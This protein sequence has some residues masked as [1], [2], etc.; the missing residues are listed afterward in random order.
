[1][2]LA[3]I[4]SLALIGFLTG[5]SKTSIGGI[6]LVNAALLATILPAK[7]SMGVM[8]ILLIAGDLFAIGIYKKHVEWKMLRSLIWPIIFGIFIGVYFLS[9]ATNDSL[10][11]TIGIIVLLL[12]ILYPISQRLQSSNFS[13]NLRYPKTL[14]LSLGLMTGFMSM[15]A[16][17]GGPPMSIYLL[18]RKNTVL[19][20]MGN[21]AWLFF[22]V[23]LFKVPFVFALG[24]LNF[25][26]VSYIIPAL[27][28]VPLGALLGR[29]VIGKL[30]QELFQK[31]TLISAALAGLNLLIG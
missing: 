15:V 4:L 18:L 16:N 17:S 10:K 27:P 28:L 25:Q 29:K 3:L 6:G 8:L 11:Q 2:S 9:R 30:N 22:M 19:K 24:L 26:S 1:M 21:N 12:V 31:I 23:N 13:L 20:F 7:E 5:F 14:R